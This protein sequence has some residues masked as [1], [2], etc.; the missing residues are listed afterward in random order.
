MA[1]AAARVWTP[2]NSWLTSFTVVP[3]PVGPVCLTVP[4]MASKAGSAASKASS[5]PPAMITSVAFSA[6]SVPPLMGASRNIAPFASA[7]SA[8]ALDVSI[9]TVL[10]STII[11]PGRALAMTPSGPKKTS[12]EVAMSGRQANTISHC[13]VTSAEDMAAVAPAAAISWTLGRLRLWT[14]RSKPAFSRL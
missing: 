12:S 9:P 13:R 7:A 3:V 11:W 2:T 14:V 10:W 1:S 8:Q 4:P 6:R 5:S